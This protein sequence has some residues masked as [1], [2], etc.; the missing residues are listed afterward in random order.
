VDLDALAGVV[1]RFSCIALDV[2]DLAEL[3]INPLLVAPAGARALDVRG[4][5]GAEPSP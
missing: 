3:E 1:S 5:L 4:R 2:P